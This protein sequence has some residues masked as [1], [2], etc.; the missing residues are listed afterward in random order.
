MTFCLRCALETKFKF[1]VRSLAWYRRRASEPPAVCSCSSTR[2]VHLV[3][4]ETLS[5][6]RT[7]WSRRLE[8]S[9]TCP[10]KY[11]ITRIYLPRHP[12]KQKA[13]TLLQPAPDDPSF[14]L[15]AGDAAAATATTICSQPSSVCTRPNMHAAHALFSEQQQCCGK[16]LLSRGQLENKTHRRAEIVGWMHVTWSLGPHHSVFGYPKWK[17]ERETRRAPT[18]SSNSLFFSRPCLFLPRR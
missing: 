2:D 10:P 11:N 8:L 16:Y 13:S 1:F 6:G 7:L 14:C 5:H 12:P 18:T 4:R 3:W 9:P 17:I 15:V